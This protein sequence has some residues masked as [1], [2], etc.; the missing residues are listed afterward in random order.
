MYGDLEEGFRINN[1][2][3]LVFTEIKYGPVTPINSMSNNQELKAHSI[4]T[5]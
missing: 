2:E 5:K 3:K 1:L 4:T